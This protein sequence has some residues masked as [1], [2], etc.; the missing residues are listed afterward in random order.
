MSTPAPESLS[1]VHA[2]RLRA[3]ARELEAV[4]VEILGISQ[5]GVAAGPPSVTPAYHPLDPQVSAKLSEAV[6]GIPEAARRVSALAGAPPPAP[7]AQGP[8]ATLA[9]I[10]ARL[11]R[12]EDTLKDLHPDRLQ[13][14]YGA[15]P[16]ATSRELAEL[17]E[18]MERGVHTA[19]EFIASL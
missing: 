12:L 17:C 4:V 7:A 5:D 18:T 19:R 1:W 11:G 9:A 10:S 6:A 16:G 13:A 15:M 8:R 14:R 3:A 2:N